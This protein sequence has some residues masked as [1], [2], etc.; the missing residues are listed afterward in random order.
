MTPFVQPVAGAKNLHENLAEIELWLNRERERVAERPRWTSNDESRY[1]DVIS[2]LLDTNQHRIQE[3]TRS[4]TSI[5]NFNDSLTKRLEIIR[6]DLDQRR[7][8]DIKR[9]TYVT[10]VFPPPSFA[11][12]VFSMSDAP[13]GRTLVSMMVTA[14]VALVTTALLLKYAEPL[15]TLYNWGSRGIH[16]LTSGLRRGKPSRDKEEREAESV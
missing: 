12:G 9:F 15:E 1:R 4:N 6:S 3:L 8:D 16:R 5:S 14:V 13:A 11:T 10:V 2:K 7:A